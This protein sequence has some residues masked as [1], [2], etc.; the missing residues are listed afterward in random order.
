MSGTPILSRK[1]RAVLS[2]PALTVRAHGTSNH[3]PSMV[4]RGM[5]HLH[6]YMLGGELVPKNN[7]CLSF[8]NMG[9][10]MRGAYMARPPTVLTLLTI[11]A[12]VSISIVFL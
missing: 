11:P 3:D 4:T 5:N 8:V 1:S 7:Y 12:E 9:R 10:E 2:N 6:K